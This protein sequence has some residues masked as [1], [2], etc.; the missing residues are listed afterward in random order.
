MLEGGQHAW[1]D[2]TLSICVSVLSERTPDLNPIEQVF[3]KLKALLRK[4]GERTVDTTWRRIGSLL[5]Q[6][7][8]SECANICAM[9]DM[10]PYD[11]N[12]L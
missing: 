12:A 3:A 8:P 5:A 9:P 10:L 1:C 2:P 7:A 6:F 11:V 4:V